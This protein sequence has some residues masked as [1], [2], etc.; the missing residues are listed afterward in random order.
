MAKGMLSQAP[1]GLSARQQARFNFL[2][3]QGRGREASQVGRP[4]LEVSSS[5]RPSSGIMAQARPAPAP[6]RPNIA[7][8]PQVTGTPAT[9]P[10]QAELFQRPAAP[11]EVQTRLPYQ[12]QDWRQG[13]SGAG[14]DMQAENPQ[15]DMIR[16]RQAQMMGRVPRPNPGFNPAQF[17]KGQPQ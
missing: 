14:A 7:Q 12:A 15:V 3:K 13:F 1:T 8:G 6:R 5:G 16:R 11:M 4:N 2:K 10:P 9:P 17:Y